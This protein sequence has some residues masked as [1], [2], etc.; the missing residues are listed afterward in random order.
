MLQVTQQ[1]TGVPTSAQILTAEGVAVRQSSGQGTE[2][3]HP[4]LW[5]PQVLE[6]EQ[7]RARRI[8]VGSLSPLIAF[9][10]L[11]CSQV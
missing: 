2:P 8:A 9:M 7:S 1:V 11:L 6:L 4:G 3:M 5:C 10:V